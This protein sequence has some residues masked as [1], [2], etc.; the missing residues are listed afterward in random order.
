MSIKRLLVGGG[1]SLAV[2]LLAGCGGINGSYSPS[3]A[4]FFLPG[5]VQIP[6]GSPSIQSAV[7]DQ[8]PL[9]NRS[10]LIQPYLSACAFPSP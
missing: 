5:L 6:N 4:S 1:S 2:L 10:E 7:T 8:V 3:P 9:T